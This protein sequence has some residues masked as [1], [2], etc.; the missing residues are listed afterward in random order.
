MNYTRLD[1]SLITKRIIVFTFII[2]LVYFGKDVLKPLAFAV[3]FSLL[4]YPVSKFFERRLPRFMSISIVIFLVIILILG[5]LSFFGTQVY[6]LFNNIKDFGSNLQNVFHKVLDFVDNKIIQNQFE[7]DS[8]VQMKPQNFLNPA[9]F[10]E[11]TIV[12]SSGFLFSA[13]LVLVYTF[14]FLLYRTS[15]KTFII[16]H[17]PEDTR[18][19][20]RKM[21]Y[22]IQKV[23]QNYFFGLFII[24]MILGVL[25]GLGLW[26]I[27]IDYAFFFGFFAAFLAIIPYI[28]TFIGGMLPF[29]YALINYDNIWISILVL[30]WYMMVQTIEGNILT[31][32]IVG[33]KVSL[34]PLFALIILLIGELIWGI[35]GM[36]LF[37]PLM[38]I[39]KVILDNSD[40]FKSYS[41]LLGSDF[42]H[43][44][45][46]IIPKL[47]KKKIRSA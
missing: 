25:N 32:K 42:G 31:P 3:F 39:L 29:L 6:Q 24:I 34:N 23:S 21:L 12:N 18:E 46:S 33:S 22:T 47:K 43:D 14:L 38:A 11:Q 13:G 44:E 40:S 17:Y 19:E 10:V 30:L 4:L 27:G 1:L 41:Q 2:A 37:I 7:L 9:E 8:L 5:I 15:F 26:L 36:I 28:G 35:A 45:K 16:N 20:V